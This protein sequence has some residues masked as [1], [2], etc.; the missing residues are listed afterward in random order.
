MKVIG[1]KTGLNCGS[2]PKTLSMEHSV[3][4]QR[5]VSI[6]KMDSF[7]FGF[8]SEVSVEVGIEGF[9]SVTSTVRVSWGLGFVSQLRII[10]PSY[11][12]VIAS[13]DFNVL[14]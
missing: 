5:D 3:Q 2:L 10:N 6:S 11:F 1:V 13:L 4:Y 14:C 7:E 12:Y 9:G 8:S